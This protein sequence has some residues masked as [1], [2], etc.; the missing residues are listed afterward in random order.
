MAAAA[1]F[2]AFF[3]LRIRNESHSVEKA[4][5]NNVGSGGPGAL[6]WDTLPAV[7]NPSEYCLVCLLW[8]VCWYLSC[9]F[10]V[11]CFGVLLVS[12]CI[13]RSAAL[14]AWSG[15]RALG[16]AKDTANAHDYF[17]KILLPVPCVSVSTWHDGIW[18]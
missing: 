6:G 10:A 7:C 3:L 15:P 14:A 9:V 8:A 18:L 12:E 1:G 13:C 2:V 16:W 5:D 4:F 11:G 17:N